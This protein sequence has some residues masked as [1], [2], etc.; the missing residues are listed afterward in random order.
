MEKHTFTFTL[1]AGMDIKIPEGESYSQRDLLLMTSDILRANGAMTNDLESI[2]ASDFD[3]RRDEDGSSYAHTT[4]KT[5]YITEQIGENYDDCQRKALE[6][7]KNCD[8]T[9]FPANNNFKT[10]MT[11]LEIVSSSAQMYNDVLKSL[12]ELQKDAECGYSK[13]FICPNLDG[14]GFAA[15][16]DI[17]SLELSS[18]EVT[19]YKSGDYT[20]SVYPVGINVSAI[21]EDW[22]DRLC[23]QENK[24]F[25]AYDVSIKDGELSDVLQSVALGKV[26]LELENKKNRANIERD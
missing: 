22:V 1:E 24:V 7:L 3:I 19:V 9:G 16:V 4:L 10:S 11:S 23:K 13:T 5:H 2:D 20:Q 25:T 14:C 15:K 8:K 12:T 6:A 18:A 17:D 21:G 26:E